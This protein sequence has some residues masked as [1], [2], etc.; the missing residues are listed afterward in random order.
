MSKGFHYGL[1]SVVLSSSGSDMSV[2]IVVARNMCHGSYRVSIKAP[3]G[4]L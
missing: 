3:H 2:Y 4:V 1:L